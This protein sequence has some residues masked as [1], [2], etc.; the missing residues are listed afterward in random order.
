MGKHRAQQAAIDA[1]VNA[2][3]R[4][5][6]AFAPMNGDSLLIAPERDDRTTPENP[7]M[8]G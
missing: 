3:A 2:F 4:G 5:D 7:E 1:N 8:L 6:L